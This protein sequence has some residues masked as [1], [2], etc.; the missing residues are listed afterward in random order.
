M[1][2]GLSVCRCW[3]LTLT[4]HADGGKAGKTGLGL[5]LGLWTGTTLAALDEARPEG[6]LHALR[7]TERATRGLGWIGL[8][9]RLRR[10]LQ[11]PELP[12]L[13]RQLEPFRSDLTARLSGRLLKG[14][15]LVLAI[16][17]LPVSYLCWLAFLAV[18]GVVL[19]AAKVSLVFA[20]LLLPRRSISTRIAHPARFPPRC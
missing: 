6:T 19:V 10:R 7:G 8:G 9:L 17:S 11:A 1:F 14:D 2:Q 16:P 13:S 5:G 12:T 20:R 3:T 15:G 18:A 4:L